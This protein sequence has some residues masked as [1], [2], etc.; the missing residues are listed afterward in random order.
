MARPRTCR[1]GNLEEGTVAAG[2]AREER[3]EMA[4]DEGGC[5]AS[6]VICGCAQLSDIVYGGEGA[7]R[8][9]GFERVELHC[10]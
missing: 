8:R 10:T 4:F 2:R 5:R 3:E 9:C 1:A 7:G 6:I